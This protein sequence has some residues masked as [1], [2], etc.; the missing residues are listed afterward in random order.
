MT[1]LPR[2]LTYTL[3]ATAV[4]AAGC[5]PDSAPAPDANAKKVLSSCHALGGDDASK[6]LG[7]T[8]VANRMAGDDAP[9]SICAYKD[10]GN[11]TVALVK[12]DKNGKYPDHA[13]ALA[14]DQKSEQNLFSGNIKP[15]KYHPAD[16]FEAGSFYGDIT[17]RFDTLE[18]ELGT[19]VGG[20]KMLFV[21]NN[22]KDFATG[23]KQ[24]ADMAHKV[25]ENMQ[26]GTAYVTM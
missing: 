20:V 10:T 3:A 8:V 11:V 4:L 26:N 15:P 14:A 2:I 12:I 24:A 19:F 13:A 6:I 23:E 7:T 21:I 22:P 5:S 25:A 17:P 16:G 9:I 18:V 1:R